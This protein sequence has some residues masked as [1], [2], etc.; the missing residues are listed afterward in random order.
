MELDTAARYLSQAEAACLALDARD[1]L[2][3]VLFEHGGLAAQQGDLTGA[4]ARY[5]AALHAAE[6]NPGPANT[7][8]RILSYNN[9]AYHSLLL[10]ALADAQRYARTAA[11]LAQRAGLLR[12]LSYIWSTTGEIA[13][14]RGD[15]HAAEKAFR[16]ALEC[17]ERFGM[18]ERIAGIHANLGLVAR[19]NGEQPRAITLLRAA[20]AEADAVGVHHLA[21]QIRI[22]LAALVPDPEA[23]RYL[24]DART[25]A[26]HGGRARLLAEIERVGNERGFSPTSA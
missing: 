15:T 7:V 23:Q 12:L 13:L 4:L 20:L 3:R 19:A 25:L 5:R 24:A 6:A 14:A 9:L 2:P 11:R 1:I 16:D 18:A 22:W 21:T 8:W 17:A 26:A 10:G